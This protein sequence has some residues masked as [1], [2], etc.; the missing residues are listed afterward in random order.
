MN[1]DLHTHSS[2][3]DGTLTPSEL[4]RFAYSKGFKVLALCDHDCVAG[5]ELAQQEA[6]QLSMTVVPGIELS[7][8]TDR[9]IHILGYGINPQTP[10]LQ[11]FC[12]SLIQYRESRAYEILK[13]LRNLGKPVEYDQVAQYAK[14][15]I[16]KPHIARAMID[17]GYV[18]SIQEAFDLFLDSG[19]PADIPKQTLTVPDAIDLID[20]AGGIAVLAHPMELKLED[21]KLYTLIQSWKEAGL[22]GLEAYHPS[23]NNEQAA[24]LH[25]YALHHSLLI[26]GGS[27]FHRHG[28]GEHVLGQGLER[29]R[30]KLADV[31]H[32]FTRLEMPFPYVNLSNQEILSANS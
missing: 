23:A 24:T 22:I 18:Q 30:T 10:R 9:E 13:K 8:T 5:I 29:W 31:A 6:Q 32:L 3:S 7:C 16:G 12:D 19:R 20:K 2:C 26:T 1:I 14:G 11:Q 27:D 15:A 25:D 4:V 17:Y 28:S 21:E